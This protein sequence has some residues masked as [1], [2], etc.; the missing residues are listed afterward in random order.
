MSSN[1]EILLKPGDILY[2]EG[3]PPDSGYVVASGEIV[4]FNSTLGRRIDCERRGSGSIVGE[5]SILTGQPRAVTVEA[6]T[7]CRIFRISA[8]QILTRY[9][10]L[11]P[12][13]RACIETS[14][15]F[16]ATFTK[17]LTDQASDAPLVPGTLQ[18]ADWLIEQC[19]FEADIYRAFESE[20]FTMVY[21]PIVTLA[22]G[23]VAGAESLMRWQH[24]EQGEISPS[25]FIPAAETMGSIKELTE[26]AVAEACAALLRMQQMSALP[27]GFFL[28]VN[29]SG[30]DVAR[31]GFVDFVSLMLERHGLAP[32]SLRLEL[33]ESDLIADPDT[34]AVNLSRLRHLGCGLSIDDFGTGY[35]NPAYLKSLPLS[36]IKIDRTFASEARTESVSRSIVRMLLGLGREMGVDMIAEGLETAEDVQALREL[37]CAFGQGFV[38]HKPMAEADLTRQ[39]KQEGQARRGVA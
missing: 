1:P 32:G 29:V 13:L 6:V 16:A 18:N 36:A 10:K 5:L 28:S 7:H 20:Q 23:S 37:G 33:T 34:A 11:D 8:K 3:D 27:E 35:S 25:R 31:P 17:T 14:I 24:P 12:V 9:N 4:L 15:L 26:F 39:M 21:Q 19:K 30:Q 38:F 22:D 2:R